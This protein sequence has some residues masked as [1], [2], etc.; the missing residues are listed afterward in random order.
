MR[1]ANYALY[2]LL[3]AHKPVKAILILVLA[4]HSLLCNSARAGGGNNHI[5][6]RSPVGGRSA[7]ILVCRLQ[8][9]NY[10][11]NLIKVSAGA[12]G[13]VQNGTNDTLGIDTKTALTAWVLDCPS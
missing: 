8:S 7:R 9:L 10:P 1:G 13:I 11:L 6:S 3:L 5:V 12:E 2:L 4:F